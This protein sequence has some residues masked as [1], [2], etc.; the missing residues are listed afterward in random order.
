MKNNHLKQEQHK[1]PVHNIPDID[2]IDL[3]NEGNPQQE[4]RTTR[5]GF[6]ALDS[7][8]DIS[9]PTSSQQREQDSA[10]A[11]KGGWRKLLNVHV[12][13]F[14]VVIG[15]IVFIVF[16]F[17]NWGVEISQE[18]IFKDGLGTYDDT[19][20]EPLPLIDENGNIVKTQLENPV[21]VAFGNAPFA[22]ERDSE[23]NLANLIEEATG[24]TVYNCAVSGS[25]MA[26]ESYAYDSDVAPMDAFCFYWLVTLATGGDIEPYYE[27]AA[28]ALGD[29]LPP[30]AEEVVETLTTL[31][32][33]TVD[34]ITVMYDATD[35]LMGHPMYS[36][37][38]Y[39]DTLQF[40]GNMEA[41]IELLQSVYPHIRI[42]VM[43]PTYAYAVDEDGNYVSS[44]MY[45]YGQDVLSTYVIKQYGSCVSRSV[46]F[47]DHLYGTITE[48]NAQDYLIDNLHINVEGRKLIAERFE[49]FLN[50][51]SKGYA[52]TEE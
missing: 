31:D 12:L 40:T 7:E 11:S 50:Y 42:I 6:E 35:Y 29:D 22:D 44:D 25:Y 45:T 2:I 16:R 18:D 43:S 52:H 21:I 32:F 30:E 14:L 5:N 10:P 23:D 27:S 3:E 46:S 49:Y 38:N 47:V 51:Y 19:F 37:T 20:D 41:G 28:Q 4:K 39:T 17:K 13:F 15:I 9:S 1:S 48:D 26:A 24:G 33:N 34:V 36:D 8:P